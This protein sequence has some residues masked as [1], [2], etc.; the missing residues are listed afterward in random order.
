MFF[1]AYNFCAVLLFQKPEKKQQKQ[2]LTKTRPVK[3]LARRSSFRDFL[4]PLR[5]KITAA[6]W[7][8]W[9]VRVILLFGLEAWPLEGWVPLSWHFDPDHTAEF[10]RIIFNQF[11][12]A[13]VLRFW[14]LFVLFIVLFYCTSFKWLPLRHRSSFTHCL[15]FVI[16]M[17]PNCSCLC[18]SNSM[19]HMQDI[20]L[21][22]KK[23]KRLRCILMVWKHYTNHCFLTLC[24]IFCI[25]VKSTIFKP[26]AV[27]PSGQTNTKCTNESPWFLHWFVIR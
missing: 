20:A 9:Q 18:I 11:L 25:P 2:V 10:R 26:R 4:F 19:Q 23:K 5:A 14:V 7:T 1:S 6:C 15:E 24:Y 21:T 17:L 3:H 22:L 12:F 27:P 16:I 13:K 8:S